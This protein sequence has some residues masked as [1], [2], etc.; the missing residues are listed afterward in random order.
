MNK[1]SICKIIKKES[2]MYASFVTSPQK[3]KLWPQN[4][5]SILTKVLNY[6]I[7]Y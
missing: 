4:M 5:G 7:Q 6:K 1:I 2:E 3:K